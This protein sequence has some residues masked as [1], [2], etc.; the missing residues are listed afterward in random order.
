[1]RIK[2]LGWRVLVEPN[3]GEE[4]VV[5]PGELQKLGFEV[6]QGMDADEVRRSILSLEVGVIV[7][8]GPLAWMRQDMQGMR[9]PDHWLPWAKIGDRVIFS[10]YA[11]KLVRDPDVADY[12]MLM[13]DEDIIMVIEG[14]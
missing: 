10:R 7:D 3:K 6:K 9:S 1:M 8:I 11:G 5:I 14:A 4:G 13:N 2:P 12:Y